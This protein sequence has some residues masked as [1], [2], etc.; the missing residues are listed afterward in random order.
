MHKCTYV[1]SYTLRITNVSGKAAL[2]VLLSSSRLN[3]LCLEAG[4]LGNGGS[5][6][7]LN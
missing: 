6:S 5:L 7:V 4:L 2:V 3:L 1:K